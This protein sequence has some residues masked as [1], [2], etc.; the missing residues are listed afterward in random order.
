MNLKFSQVP[1]SNNSS[2]VPHAIQTLFFNVTGSD[3]GRPAQLCSSPDDGSNGKKSIDDLNADGINGIDGINGNKDKYFSSLIPKS[4]ENIWYKQQGFGPSAYFFDHL[5]PVM[6]KNITSEFMK[7]WES[8]KKIANPPADEFQEPYTLDKII[9]HLSGSE[10]LSSSIPEQINQMKKIK[11]DFNSEVWVNSIS[12][13]QLF[14]IISTW[15]WSKPSDENFAKRLL[16]RFDFDGDGRLNPSEFILLSIINNAKILGEI[17]CKTH[18]YNKIISD[19]IDPIFTYLDCNKDNFVSSEN[20]WVGMQS[21]RRPTWAYSMYLCRMP[22][23]LNNNF[24]TTSCNDFILKNFKE[25]DGFLNKQEFRIGML[26][27]YWD[28]HTDINK[29]YTDDSKNLKGVRWANNGWKDIACDT[30]IRMLPRN[31]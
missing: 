24:R 8:A 4:K 16:D 15:G 10:P 13:A 23:V 30:T 26:L 1:K 22:T 27:G 11:K 6:Q 28:R 20:L 5:D 7:I 19:L 3:L 25:K 18:C 21:L 14:K 2:T 9:F 12:V 17:E 31:K 29:V